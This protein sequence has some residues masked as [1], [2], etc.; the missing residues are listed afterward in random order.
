MARNIEI[1]ARIEAHALMQRLG[2]GP[3][4]LIDGAYVDLLAG[5][6]RSA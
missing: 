5:V 4:Q 2:I 6:L 3:A 1:K